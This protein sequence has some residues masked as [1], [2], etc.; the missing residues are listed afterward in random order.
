M[1]SR[2]F[3]CNCVF[4]CYLLFYRHNDD[5]NVLESVQEFPELLT[6]KF[7]SQNWAI[8]ILFYLLISFLGLRC[9]NLELYTYNIYLTIWND[10]FWKIF[11]HYFSI[12]YLNIIVIRGFTIHIETCLEVEYPKAIQNIYN[13]HACKQ[14]PLVLKTLIKPLHPLNLKGLQ[15]SSAG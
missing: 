12:T 14:R 8:D 9:G 3:C 5:F 15:S 1:K 2:S 10:N 13:S 4:I 7:S 6:N 11:L